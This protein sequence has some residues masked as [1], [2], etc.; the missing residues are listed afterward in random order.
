MPLQNYVQ[1]IIEE[2]RKAPL[3]KGVLL[4]LSKFYRTGVS[5]RNHAYDQLWLKTFKSPLPVISVGNIVAGGTGKTP[6][7]RLLLQELTPE[8]G[9][10]LLTRGY[11]SQIEKSGEVVNLAASPSTPEMCGDEPFWLSSLFPKTAVWVGKNRVLSAQK[12]FEEG[13]E[14]LLLDDGMQYRRLHRDIDIV[15]MDAQ[16][17]FGKNHYLPRGYL[18]DSRKRLFGADLIVVN[19]ADGNFDAVCRKDRSLFERPGGRGRDGP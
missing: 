13:A 12:A 2:R 1:D 7:I 17:L 19:H 5:L 6:L 9:V 14:C 15:V 4:A 3:A 10:A 16:D 8:C 11:R 18:R